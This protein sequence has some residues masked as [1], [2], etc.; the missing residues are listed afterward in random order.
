MEK[1]SWRG[2]PSIWGGCGRADRG[3]S[4]LPTL[5]VTSLTRLANA[6]LTRLAARGPL[7]QDLDD[8]AAVLR[9]TVTRV[10]RRNRL[11]F[12][13][14]DHIDLVKRNLVLLVE[15]TLHGFSALPPLFFFFPGVSPVLGV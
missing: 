10:V 12:T 3:G 14:G 1:P 2:S 4:A 15:I 8:D 9:A 13:V 5:G 11:L 6:S 7:R